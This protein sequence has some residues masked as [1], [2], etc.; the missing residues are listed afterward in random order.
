MAKK[1]KKT[2]GNPKWYEEPI[3]KWF[4]IISGFV[5]IA[6]LGYAFARIQSSLEFRME[7]FEIKQDFNEKLQKQINACKEEKQSLQNQRVK[8]I[9][10]VVKRL[11]NKINGDKQ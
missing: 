1:K 3:K 8:L 2:S 5:F 10:N 11:E 6:G 7:K 4:A 9:E